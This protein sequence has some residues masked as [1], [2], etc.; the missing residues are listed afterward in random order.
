[1]RNASICAFF[2][3]TAAIATPASAT[4]DIRF[5]EGA[6]K[7]RFVFTNA[8]TC[9]FGP[10]TLVLDL[11]DSAAGLIFDTTDA[12]AGVEVFQPFEIVEGAQILQSVSEVSDGDNRIEL[13]LSA[14]AP[15]QSVAFTIDVDDTLRHSA[16]GQI[17]VADSEIAGAS[18]RLRSAGA[19]KLGVFDNTSRAI[20][21]TNDCVG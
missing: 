5:D 7:D 12:G 4:I 6:P 13:T 16:L 2:A 10:M 8:G 3:A 15:G 17:Q 11:S 20:I 18:V 9:A 1:M 14:M 19:E 21:R